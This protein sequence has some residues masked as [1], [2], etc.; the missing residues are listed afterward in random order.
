[1]VENS[2]LII[3]PA[4][5]YLQASDPSAFSTFST[6]ICFKDKEWFQYSTKLS[7]I[8]KYINASYELLEEPLSYCEGGKCKALLSKASA[9][10]C[11]ASDIDGWA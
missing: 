11:I 6:S 8:F 7:N 1:M 3:A 5:F 10:S 9:A 2:S 4:L